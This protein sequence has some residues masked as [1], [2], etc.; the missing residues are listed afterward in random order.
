MPMKDWV[1]S[2][3]QRSALHRTLLVAPPVALLVLAGFWTFG[4]R[5]GTQ[6]YTAKV[7]KGD[8]AQVVQATGTINAV[9]SV[10]VGSQVSGNIAQLFVDFNSV[11]KK[12]Q[13]IAQ[14]DPAIFHAQLLQAQA[15]L[16][17]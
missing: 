13:V 3:W 12:G 15:D 6:Y 7:E 10:Q 17:N 14:I 5:Q 2:Q 9:T 16:D 4:N 11:V 1:R 8:I